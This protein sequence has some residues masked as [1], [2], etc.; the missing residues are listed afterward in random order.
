MRTGGPGPRGR[1][2]RRVGGPIGNSPRRSDEHRWV[3]AD[4]AGRLRLGDG[5]DIALRPFRPGDGSLL[6][7]GFARLSPRSRY[8]R[9]LTPSPG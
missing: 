6:V 8:R 9:F 5:T 7:A 2:C 3:V 4:P 1:C